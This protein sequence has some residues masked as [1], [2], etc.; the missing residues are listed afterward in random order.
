MSPS[1][2]HIIAASC[3]RIPHY[4]DQQ[5][6]LSVLYLVSNFRTSSKLAQAELFQMLDY[7]QYFT[8]YNNIFLSFFLYFSSLTHVCRIDKFLKLKQVAALVQ[9]ICVLKSNPFDFWDLYTYTYKVDE[10]YNAFVDACILMGPC[11][12]PFEQ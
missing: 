5:I 4:K 8:L 3:W 6:I 10:I 9:A 11:D 1:V 12:R 7:F 2:L